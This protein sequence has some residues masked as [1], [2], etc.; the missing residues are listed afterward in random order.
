VRKLILTAT[1]IAGAIALAGSVSQSDAAGKKVA[2]FDTGPSNPFIATLNKAFL[3]RAKEL[4]LEVT[5]FDN[6][7]DPAQ[8]MQQIDDAIA[9][10]F[11]LLAIQPSSEKAIIPALARAKAAGIPVVIVN[12]DPK[13]GYEDLYVSFIGED[14]YELGRLA[15]ESV[16]KALKD[17]RRDGDAKVALITGA[18]AEGV[19]QRRVKGFTEALS[20]N[21]NVKIVATEDAYWDTVKSEQIAG[22]LYA[23]FAPQG[24]LDVLYGMAD[25][26]AAAAVRA[27]EAANIALGTEKGKLIVVGSNCM[28]DGIKA[29]KEG[30]MY[31]TGIQI[32]KRTGKVSA[33]IV[34]DFLAGK[35]V[36]K[37]DLEH[38]ETITKDNVATWEEQCTY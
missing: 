12:N 15:G 26:Q 16:L 9:R 32:P 31:S 6:N 4:G 24:G 27:A 20:A 34:A 10:K 14:N 19:A 35:T 36:P 8:Q 22:Q 28:T 33:E 37:Q 30:K 1:A 25:N 5:V 38:I 21:P 29:I 7:Y 11:D 23:K 2:Y 13:E 17:A 18:L 3:D